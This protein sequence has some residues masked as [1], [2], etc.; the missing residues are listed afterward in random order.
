M[1]LFS[2]T[3]GPDRRQTRRLN[4]FG[5]LCS[6]VWQKRDLKGYYSKKQRQFWLKY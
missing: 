2:K 5:L 3:N 1:F 4:D 6:I